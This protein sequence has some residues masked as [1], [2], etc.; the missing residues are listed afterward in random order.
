MR[1]IGFARIKWENKNCSYE[2]IH[3][4]LIDLRFI[5]KNF[6]KNDNSITIDF[7][8]REISQHLF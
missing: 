6:D 7:F 1:H 8:K 3:T 5:I 4:F 2:K